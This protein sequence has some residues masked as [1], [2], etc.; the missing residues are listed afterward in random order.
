MNTKRLEE[1]LLRVVRLDYEVELYYHNEFAIT[2]SFNHLNS[3]NN[4]LA[5]VNKDG[6]IFIDWQ[7][8]NKSKVVIPVINA[9]LSE[10]QCAIGN[11]SKITVVTD[12]IE[13]YHKKSEQVY[14]AKYSIFNK[15]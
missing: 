14:N 2:I 4:A 8:H 6:R 15:I 1:K 9:I 13:K 3:Y 10:L 11:E 7:Y 12:I 5:T